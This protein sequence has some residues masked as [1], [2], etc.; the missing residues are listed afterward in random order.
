M[1][2][3]I[4][5]LTLLAAFCAVGVQA[6][7]NSIGTDTTPIPPDP[8]R[9]I[10]IIVQNHAG[11]GLNDKV[12]ALEDLVGSRVAGNG[13]AVI[14]RDVVTR[15]VADNSSGKDSNNGLNDID[16]S[17][18]N[19]SSALRLAQNLGADYILVP[20]LVSLGTEKKT[21]NG[22]GISTVNI[23]HRLRVSYK[24]VEGGQGGAVK[25]GAFVSEKNTRQ[26]DELQTE[27]TDT[28]NELLDDAASQLSEAIIESGKT[29]PVEVAKA[30]RVN[31]SVACTM[32]DPRQQPVLIS[33]LGLTPDNKVV[34]TNQPVAV[35]AMEV[36]VELDGVA[37]GS[38]PGSF[39][40]LPGLHK[41]RLSREGFDTWE[42]T[43][44]IYDGQKLRV[45]LQMSPDGYA[46]WQDTT[47]FLASLDNTRKLTDAEVKKTEGIAEFFKNSHYRVDTKDNIQVTYK[48]LF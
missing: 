26:T 19:D 4:K 27:D 25:G 32:T 45:A 36:T 47:A 21:Y 28:L 16:K 33:V 11:A 13:F 31:F 24:I 48:S 35:Q 6:Q 23:T 37:L 38:A 22:N 2:K 34:V 46:R 44:N 41:L 3:L 10:A 5:S 30:A 40:G 39:Q 29:L 9:K 17:L 20:T 1:K 12:E 42:R 15:A 7:N 14:S 8:Q 43:I 18:E